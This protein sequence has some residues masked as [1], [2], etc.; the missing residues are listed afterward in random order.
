MNIEIIETTIEEL[1]VL[2][3]LFDQYMVFYKKPS[4]INKYRSYL[5]E[6]LQN[7]E[8]NAYLAIDDNTNNPLGF[9]L[10][11]HSFSSVSLGR[12]VV[13]NDLFVMPEYRKKGIAERLINSAFDL[14]KQVGAIRVDLGTGKDN[15]TAQRLYEKIG[16]VKDEDFYTYS[17]II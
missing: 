9:V 2:T 17:Y 5:K 8:A 1:D 4:D 15:Y 16:F 12:I 3:E 14:A 13:L 7:K 6:R 10:N 11:Y